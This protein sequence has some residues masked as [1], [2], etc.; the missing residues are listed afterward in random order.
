VGAEPAKKN[1]ED[2][3]F[4]EIAPN[5]EDTHCN[6]IVKIKLNHMVIVF[7]VGVGLY[8]VSKNNNESEALLIVLSPIFDE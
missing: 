7:H 6:K 2:T 3:H 4:N 1:Y 5:Y 8:L